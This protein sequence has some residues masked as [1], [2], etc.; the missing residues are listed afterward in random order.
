MNENYNL[1]IVKNC[2]KNLDLKHVKLKFKLQ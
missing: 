1:I 2:A